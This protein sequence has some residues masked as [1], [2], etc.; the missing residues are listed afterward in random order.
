MVG[1]RRTA[2]DVPS[3][4][5]AAHRRRRLAAAV[6]LGVGVLGLLVGFASAS[7]AVATAAT[8]AMTSGWVWTWWLRGPNP[9]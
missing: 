4:A 3:D 9:P 5:V 7:P 6:L 1:D 2:A 8:V